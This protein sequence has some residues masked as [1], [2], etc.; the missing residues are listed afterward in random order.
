M[1]LQYENTR[2]LLVGEMTKLEYR[3]LE[4]S[5]D[6]GRL[7]DSNITLYD[8]NALLIVLATHQDM[9]TRKITLCNDRLRQL[10]QKI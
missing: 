6:L 2:A 4:A 8:H 10:Y 9:L 7:K 5:S 1:Q 3:L